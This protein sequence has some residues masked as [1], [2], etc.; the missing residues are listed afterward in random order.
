MAFP[1]CVHVYLP[2]LSMRWCTVMPDAARCVL[3]NM[4]YTTHMAC[5]PASCLACINV[6]SDRVSQDVAYETER[7]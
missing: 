3:A 6:F 7:Y 2:F 5:A 1:M 4:P